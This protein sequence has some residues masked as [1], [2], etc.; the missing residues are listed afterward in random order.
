M[1]ENKEKLSVVSLIKSRKLESL[2]LKLKNTNVVNLEKDI[3]E[4]TMKINELNI[5]AL[6]ANKS[7][8]RN[9]MKYFG[10]GLE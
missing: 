1:S 9:K 2:L 3:E 10:I 8:K 5:K 6:Q 7:I 4:I